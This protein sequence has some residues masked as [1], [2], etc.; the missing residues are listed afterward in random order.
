MPEGVTVIYLFVIVTLASLFALAG[1]NLTTTWYF[2]RVGAKAQKQEAIGKKSL[3]A[4]GSHQ[5]NE[6]HF[7]TAANATEAC[8][9]PVINTTSVPAPVANGL[10]SWR[11]NYDVPAVFRLRPQK[12]P[13][14]NP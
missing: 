14:S 7:P 6:T 3:K 2:W 9:V 1:H 10:Q 11:Q 5:H 13:L 8:S 12:M 4:D